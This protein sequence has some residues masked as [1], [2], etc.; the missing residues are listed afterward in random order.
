MAETDAKARTIAEPAL[1]YFFSLWNRGFNDA[2]N[3]VVAATHQVRPELYSEQSFS[4]FRDGNRERVNFHPLS[5]ADLQQSGFIIAGS[6]DTVA[7]QL[8]QQ[9]AQVGA[10]HFMGMFHIGDLPHL[11]VIDS[12]NLFHRDVMPQV[13]I[14]PT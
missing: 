14:A 6:P 10:A 3:T 5:W 8:V 13:V 7:K 1:R 4:Y 11:R 9:M 2:A 12:L